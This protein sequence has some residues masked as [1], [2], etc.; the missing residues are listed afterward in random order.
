[1]VYYDTYFLTRIPTPSNPVTHAIT[2]LR[3]KSV[4]AYSFIS[5]EIGNFQKDSLLHPRVLNLFL[6]HAR[7]PENIPDLLRLYIESFTPSY[8]KLPYTIICVGP[9][10]MYS[11]NDL[12]TGS[13]LTLIFPLSL[14]FSYIV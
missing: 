7:F 2:Q 6:L 9:M 4:E 3:L 1:M 8:F 14:F 5:P 12:G 11:L 10:A 13:L